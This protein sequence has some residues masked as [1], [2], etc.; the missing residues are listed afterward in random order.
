LL[1]RRRYL[2]DAEIREALADNLCRCGI[3]D[4]VRRQ[5]KYNTG[6][7]D[8]TDENQVNPLRRCY[9]HLFYN[10]VDHYN[11]SDSLPFNP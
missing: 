9:I 8:L 1:K 10:L 7:E 5:A 3:Y 4:R 11:Y 6:S 2:T